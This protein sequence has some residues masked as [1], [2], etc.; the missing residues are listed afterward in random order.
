MAWEQV[1]EDSIQAASA[2]VI[3]DAADAP[4]RDTLEQISLMSSTLEKP[5]VC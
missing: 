2:D 5:V 3:I 4:G 1:D